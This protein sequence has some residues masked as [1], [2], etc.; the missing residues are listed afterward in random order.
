MNLNGSEGYYKGM[1]RREEGKIWSKKA[2][3]KNGLHVHI[4]NRK[5]PRIYLLI[6]EFDAID[7]HN[8][9]SIIQKPFDLCGSI[10]LS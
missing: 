5:L 9:C 10:V 7:T 4:K 2:A 1:G 8:G 3:P 6:D